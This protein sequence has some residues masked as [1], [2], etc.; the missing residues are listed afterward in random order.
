MPWR[1]QN[2]YP[3]SPASVQAH[4]PVKEGVY[5]IRS[6]KTWVYLGQSEDLRRRL[7]EHLQDLSHPMHRYPK[8]EFSYETTPTAGD[9][10]RQLLMEFRPVCNS[11]F[12]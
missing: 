9:R 8:L 11:V 2:G 3:L 7:M 1:T 6:G 10:L 5:G 4:A 12:D